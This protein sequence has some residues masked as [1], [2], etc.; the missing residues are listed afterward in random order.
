[1]TVKELI[2]RLEILVMEDKGDYAIYSE[3]LDD[4]VIY[5]SDKNKVVYL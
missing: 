1:M 4:N 2:E 3:D 5:V